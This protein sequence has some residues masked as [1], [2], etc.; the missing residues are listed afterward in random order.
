MS[1]L[2]HS[3]GALCPPSAHCSGASTEAQQRIHNHSPPP[4]TTTVSITVSYMYYL[5]SDTHSWIFVQPPV[6]SI[7]PPALLKN[8]VLNPGAKLLIG[9]NIQGSRAMTEGAWTYP[10]SPV[11]PLGQ[12]VH[13]YVTEREK[14]EGAIE[15]SLHCLVMRSVK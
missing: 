5:C 4:W 2:F 9:Q 13:Q 1:L 15:K 6:G 12:R 14:N 7:Q 11:L 8:K 10:R 3:F